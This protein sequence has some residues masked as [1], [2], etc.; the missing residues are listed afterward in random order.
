MAHL[1]DLLVRWRTIIIVCA[2]VFGFIIY[3]THIANIQQRV[4]TCFTGE[5]L[6][7]TL[8]TFKKRSNVLESPVLRH[9]RNVPTNSSSSIT[10]PKVLMSSVTVYY[11]WCQSQYFEFRHYLSVKSAIQNL[12]PHNV[13][14]YYQY[15]PY[16]DNKLYNT[17]LSEL[18]QEFPFFET[19]EASS[20]SCDNGRPS[21]SFVYQLTNER[22]GIYLGENTIIT[23]PLP[24]KYHTVLSA[25]RE[26]TG[27]IEVLVINE[28]LPCEP[29][30]TVIS[31]QS[32]LLDCPLVTGLDN[33]T[34]LPSCIVLDKALFPKHIW[35]LENAFGRFARKIFYGSSDV[36]VL[37][38]SY[39]ELVPNI[40]HMIWFGGGQMDFLF[41][42][43]VLSFLYVAE[44]D[45]V[46]IH[47]D[48]PPSGYYW[49]LLK[50]NP[51]VIHMPYYGS[52]MIYGQNV[53]H[54]YHK[55]DVLRVEL[56]YRYGGI[57]LDTD[58]VFV[59]ALD[60]EMR[61]Y[62]AIASYDWIDWDHPFPA[63]IN[64]G[65]TIGKKK[66]EFWRLFRE[67]M[68]WFKDDDFSWNGLRRPY[69]VLERHRNLIRI[70]PRL[71]VIC[72]NLKCHATWWEKFQDAKFHPGNTALDWRK[73]AYAFHWTSPTPSA[74]RGY[75]QLFKSVGMFADIGKYILNRSGLTD[76][77]TRKLSDSH[78]FSFR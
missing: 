77:F 32:I 3:S 7:S 56:M 8:E 25:V 30:L 6:I 62:D 31:D 58:A 68:K 5:H 45:T 2:A 38:P 39:D 65:V 37:K 52:H 51:R 17:W 53:K 41:F 1:R 34:D 10:S 73:D 29:N 71:Q 22:K 57:Y 64:F 44:V 18:Q 46:Y 76:H 49:S 66:A 33:A 67:S 15:Y 11:V 69:Q 70:D 60:S 19:V 78:A 74:L 20:E 4:G 55:S 23:Q 47:G 54:T 75:D 63:I 40:G 21:P 72:F 26:N 35:Y 43:G 12:Q 14:L 59:R 24:E 36:P 13:I 28:K 9:K 61:G 50:D 27:D 16:I 48:Q 42:L